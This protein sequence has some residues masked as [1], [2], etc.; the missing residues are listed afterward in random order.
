MSNLKELRVKANLSQ[1]EASKRLHDVSGGRVSSDR[2]HLINAEKSGA[3]SV[4]LLEYLPL[5]YGVTIEQVYT[6]NRAALKSSGKFVQ[7]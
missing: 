5:V 2:R 6:A 4:L 1:E 7:K 3:E